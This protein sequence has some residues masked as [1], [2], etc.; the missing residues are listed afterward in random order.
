MEL[1]E[2]TQVVRR[3]GAFRNPAWAVAGFDESRRPPV[4]LA[5]GRKPSL[6]FD[7]RVGLSPE[8]LVPDREQR[9]RPGFGP[10]A[11]S[12]RVHRRVFEAPEL[13]EVRDRGAAIER[14]VFR[15]RTKAM[16][17]APNVFG[18]R[19]QGAEAIGLGDH[20]GDGF[21]FGGA[22]ANAAF[23]RYVDRLRAGAGGELPRLAEDL[24]DVPV[25]VV[26]GE[27]RFGPIAGGAGVAQV[28]GGGED[29]VF[30]V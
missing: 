17:S 27:D 1:F 12:D 15:R 14:A 19:A 11:Q 3:E 8:G 24:F 9:S 18:M 4:A 29:R 20:L 10:R 6:E 22:G 16:R 26:V 28:V 23:D 7:E 25:G 2:A 5:R 30:G 13:K 21:G